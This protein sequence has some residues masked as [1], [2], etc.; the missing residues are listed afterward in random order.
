MW[1]Q[2]A[3]ALVFE[4]GIHRAGSR[5][6]GRF[7]AKANFPPDNPSGPIRS[8]E[9]RRAIL[10][11]FI[12]SSMQVVFVACQLAALANFAWLR[13]WTNLREMEPLRWTPYMDDC[14]RIL[15]EGKETDLDIMLA[16]QA[17]CH[18]VIGQITHPSSEGVVNGEGSRPT[19]A[20]FVKALQLQLQ[21]IRQ[22]LPPEM[23]SNSQSY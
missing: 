11:V 14:V 16:F 22:W 18:I 9:E 7:P 12:I 1:T 19:A 8:M 5:D 4:L 3:V 15:R 21:D 6:V 10:G 20:Y 23:Q 17:K 13:V 2:V